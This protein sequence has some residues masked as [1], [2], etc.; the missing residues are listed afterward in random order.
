MGW[1]YH[2]PRAGKSTRAI[3]QDEFPGI[4]ASEQIGSTVYAALN[5]DCG[6]VL[7][8]VVLTDRRGGQFGYKPMD[9]SMG[10]CESDCP[11]HILN[12][13]TNPAPNEWAEQWRERCRANIAGK[14]ARVEARLAEI[15]GAERAQAECRGLFD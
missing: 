2:R 7:G 10:P 13:L 3:L 8:L 14:A 9:E 12:R 11:A 1:D 6:R 4:I 5:T 15:I